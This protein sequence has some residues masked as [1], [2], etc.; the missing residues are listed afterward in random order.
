MDRDGAAWEV[1]AWGHDASSDRSRTKFL[2]TLLL[3]ES[4]MIHLASCVIQSV[5]TLTSIQPFP[6]VMLQFHLINLLWIV[7]NAMEVSA[8]VGLFHLHRACA[9]CLSHK[10]F[11]TLRQIWHRGKG[12]CGVWCAALTKLTPAAHCSPIFLHESGLLGFHWL[13]S[14]MCDWRWCACAHSHDTLRAGAEATVEG[15]HLCL[16]FVVA[17]SFGGHGASQ[18]TFIALVALHWPQHVVCCFATNT[19]MTAGCPPSTTNWHTLLQRSS[20]AC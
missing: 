12:R 18:C 5:G 19:I 20:G 2:L 16:L 6:T 9:S 1:R 15:R 14:C 10:L 7:L 11:S 17:A 13:V 8:K 4:Q 3:I